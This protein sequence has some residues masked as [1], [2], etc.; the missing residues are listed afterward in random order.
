MAILEEHEPDEKNEQEKRQQDDGYVCHR[1]PWG[2][3]TLQISDCKLQMDDDC[4]YCNA[5]AI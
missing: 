4:G 2:K 3:F 5:I 1:T